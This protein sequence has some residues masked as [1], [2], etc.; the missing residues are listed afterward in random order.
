MGCCGQTTTTAG[1]QAAVSGCD[2][3]KRLRYT[4]GMLLGVDDFVQEQIYAGAR[5]RELARELLGYGTVRGLQVGW[6]AGGADGP[7]LSVAPGMAWLP[8]G[9]P[10]C[11]PSAQCLTLNHWLARPEI[12]PQVAQRM[13]DA[14]SPPRL[15][16]WLTL[17]YAEI[18]CDAVPIPG[19]PCRSDS[20][21]TQ[22]SRWADCFTLALRFA[23]PPQ[24]EEDAIRDFVDWLATIPVGV[25][26]PPLSEADFL[27][28]L[29][30]A[31]QAWL[32]QDS[33]PPADDFMLGLPP[34]ATRDDE[35]LLRAALRLWTTELRPLWFARRG[36]G[37][38]STLRQ[39][40]DELL[41][42]ALE[43]PLIATSAQGDWRIAPDTR[44]APEAT[45]QIAV[46]ETRRPVLLSLRL[47]QELVTQQPLPAAS[48]EVVAETAFGQAPTAGTQWSYARA[49]HSHGTPV[50]PAAGGDL[51]GTLAAATVVGLRGRAIA[52]TA[53][54]SGQALVFN[55][56]QW[57]PAPV[58]QA[59]PAAGGDLAGTLAAASVVG[60]RGKPISATLPTSAGQVLVYDGAQ[61]TPGSA[62]AAGGDF[63]GRGKLPYE[64]IVAGQV[65]VAINNGVFKLDVPAGYGNLKAHKG[66]RGASIQQALITLGFEVAAAPLL[67]QTI[68]KL[69]PLAPLDKS[70]FY[71]LYLQ[72]PVKVDGGAGGFVVLLLADSQI[73]DGKFGFRFQVEI[74]RYDSGIH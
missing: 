52:A 50:L 32:Q 27:A 34:A 28:Q 20:E 23:P 44:P 25:N 12:A 54:A 61:W 51:G 57:T 39:A 13:A 14:G 56:M 19:E 30:A 18:A 72:D 40:D 47:V 46:D 65:E 38:G 63:V 17:A 1:S 36:C 71:R 15:A 49:D 43:L 9:Q 45:H 16:V 8:S 26:S 4:L 29:R 11:V 35:L 55:G 42:A 66:E 31:A 60:L 70:P 69:T 22:D 59:L 33:P 67:N 41:L 68:V 64:L 53:P 5:R 6:D 2:E 58:L 21:L 7:Q 62:T 48:D 24:L 73:S 37:C 74:S 3:S 10:V